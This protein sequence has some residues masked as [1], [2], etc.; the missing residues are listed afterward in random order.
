MKIW[1]ILRSKDNDHN[2]KMFSIYIL[3][4]TSFAACLEIVFTTLTQHVGGFS[5]AR[6]CMSTEFILVYAL[7]SLT[8]TSPMIQS[9]ILFNL[10]WGGRRRGGRVV[11]ARAPSRVA[12]GRM[13]RCPPCGDWCRLREKRASW[14][15]SYLARNP[16]RDNDASKILSW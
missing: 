13:G 6:I 14:S 5:I 8:W 10:D 12:R 16:F 7:R 11:R 2:F 4:L 3:S 1:G 15:N 9:L